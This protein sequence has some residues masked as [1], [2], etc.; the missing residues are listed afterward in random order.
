MFK[1]FKE[2]LEDAD[3]NDIAVFLLVVILA[4][5]VLAM[6]VALIIVV[7]KGSNYNIHHSVET[8]VGTVG[9]II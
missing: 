7:T 4:V 9:G 2:M 5:F 1:K 8:I 6:S 3:L